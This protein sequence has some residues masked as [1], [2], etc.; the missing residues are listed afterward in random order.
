MRNFSKLL[1][2]IDRPKFTRVWAIL[3]ILA[4]LASLLSFFGFWWLN[5]ATAKEVAMKASPPLVDQNTGTVGGP[6]GR[7]DVDVVLAVD[8]S[9]SMEG[10]TGS[11]PDGLRLRAAE[12][13]ASSLAADIFP[14]VTRMG[15]L[16][17]GKYAVK[18]QELTE[19]EPTEA[20]QEIIKKIYNRSSAAMADW[21]EF[22]NYTNIADA[23][24][25]A[26]TM[27]QN[28]PA[29]DNNQYRKNTPAIVFM[30]DGEPT[31]GFVDRPRITNIL[32]GLV[33]K[34]T[35]IFIVL[36]RNP[37]IEER[38]ELT[39]W[40]NTWNE[41]SNE[42]PKNVKYF[43]A[44]DDTQLEVIYNTIRSRLVNEGTH[45]S[46][47]MT[48]DPLNAE[49]TITI[50]PNLLQAYLLVNK[51]VGV[52]SI[53]LVS[54]DGTG[55]DQV[56]AT[57]PT[58]NSVLQGNM[59]YRF[60]L[61][62][63]QPGQWK[64]KTDAR[65]P[66]YYLLN[67]ES[68]YTPR[69]HWPAGDPYLYGDHISQIPYYIVDDQNHPVDKPFHLK[70]GYLKTVQ[71]DDGSY[72]EE[73][74]PI[75]DLEQGTDGGEQVL[76]VDPD[77]LKGEDQLLIQVEGTADDGSLVNTSL[78]TIPV[79]LAPQ[80]LQLS[81]SKA[82][83]CGQE[84]LQFWPPAIHCSAMV[85]VSAQVIGAERLKPGTTQGTL[86]S[87]IA[88]MEIAMTSKDGLLSTSLG[89]L[90]QVGS[91]DVVVD[92]QGQVSS[93]SGDTLLWRKRQVGTVRVTWPEWVPTM[94]HR[95]L[96]L[97]V[98]L[99]I[100]AL[101]KPV[102]VAIL[103]PIFALLRMAP[104]GFYNDGNGDLAASIYDK[105]MQRRELF[106][107]NLGHS[108]QSDIHVTRSMEDGLVA[109]EQNIRPKWLKGLYRWLYNRPRGRIVAVPGKGVY[110]ERPDGQFMRASSRGTT[111]I[112]VDGVQVHVSQKDW[113]NR[114]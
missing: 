64:L 102:I 25:T 17:F 81:M 84:T 39:H 110:V 31:Y 56:I 72:V 89:P 82:M 51:P 29:G 10:A 93:N 15:Y 6:P 2:N 114:S 71:K 11:D 70:A 20:R 78:V 97:G 107:L 61:Y 44:Q 101:W 55:F 27:L 32:K 87:P 63:P 24:E 92:A 91:Y 46:G 42:F 30:T 36:L 43:E 67:T 1:K 47:R 68:I 66:L 22:V 85:P 4:L 33:D 52:Q 94:K 99:L 14:R 95:S 108:N 74:F 103:L 38:S 7:Q 13:M 26:G 80:D 50:P 37:K 105:A 90:D 35:L 16:E 9:G 65:K 57:D 112:N 53:D 54:P 77:M 76:S 83:P 69:I 88:P 41:I 40:R 21:S 98:L 3:S 86:Y 8:F 111:P 106:S 79:A 49:A 100:L 45:P 62:K 18:A 113:N 73:I 104:S 58:R 28:A 75:N 96:Y 23:F 109:G 60:Q 5:Q 34:N 12:V 19:V 59:F 48:Y